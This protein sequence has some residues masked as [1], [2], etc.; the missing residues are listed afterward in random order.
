M[1]SDYALYV[2]A[3]ILFVITGISYRQI[4]EETPKN[5]SVVLTTVFG[6]LF[7]GLGFMLRPKTTTTTVSTTSPPLATPPQEPKPEAQTPPAPQPTIEMKAET[8]IE[9]TPPEPELMRVKGIGPKREK[10]L[11]SLGI[12]GIADLSKASAK[13]LATKLELSPKITSKWI[14]HAK[15][16]VEKS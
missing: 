4:T 12:N 13:E 8:P 16:L 14:V 7:A 11:E 5:L 9:I 6:L 15:E 10:Q 3:V 1:R 2:A